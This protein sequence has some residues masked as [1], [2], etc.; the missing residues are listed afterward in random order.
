MVLIAYDDRKELVMIILGAWTLALGYL[1]ALAM[2]IHIGLGL[3]VNCGWSIMSFLQ[4]PLGKK[5]SDRA[6][7]P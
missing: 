3:V 7:S 2:K 6:R 4:C 1:A 5:A